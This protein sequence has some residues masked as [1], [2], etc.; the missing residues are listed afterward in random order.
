MANAMNQ[1]NPRAHK[2][3]IG[4]P[5]LKPKIPPPPQKEEFYGHGGFPAERTQKF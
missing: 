2:N 1:K 5:P 3:K 4:T